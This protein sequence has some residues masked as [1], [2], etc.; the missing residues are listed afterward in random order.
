MRT[1]AHEKEAIPIEGLREEN[2][3][4]P[5]VSLDEV[6][7]EN[8]SSLFFLS[9]HRGSTGISSFSFGHVLNVQEVLLVPAVP[10]A[11]IS[12]NALSCVKNGARPQGPQNL[13]ATTPLPPFL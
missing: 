10:V 6:E 9:V 5:R 1:S 4:P 3:T 11:R 13:D 2:K 8:V 12:V 7:N